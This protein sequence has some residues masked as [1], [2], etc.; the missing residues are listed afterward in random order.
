MPRYQ[1]RLEATEACH[2]AVEAAAAQWRADNGA[3]EP[4]APPARHFRVSRL[5]AADAD[6]AREICERRELQK[7]A[8]RLEDEHRAGASIGQVVT[9]AQSEPFEVVSVEELT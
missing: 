9:D 2:D 1:V 8:A 6:D 4:M 7:V 3:P 5:V